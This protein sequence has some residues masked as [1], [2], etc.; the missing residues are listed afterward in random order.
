MHVADMVLNPR[1]LALESDALLTLLR[2][3][4]PGSEQEV[5]KVPLHLKSGLFS[6]DQ[7]RA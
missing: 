1:H 2:R 5:T 6:T 3:L 4:S 7:G